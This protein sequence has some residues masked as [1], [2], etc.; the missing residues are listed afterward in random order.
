VD[1]FVGSLD[2]ELGSLVGAA[3]GLLWGRFVALRV[4]RVIQRR[5]FSTLFGPH[6][7]QM[8]A[9]SRPTNSVWPR[10]RERLGSILLPLW[11]RPNQQAENKKRPAKFLSLLCIWLVPNDGQKRAHCQLF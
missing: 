1:A 6:G 9:K 4:A 7:P 11:R 2:L 3:L 10:D 8:N 5:Q